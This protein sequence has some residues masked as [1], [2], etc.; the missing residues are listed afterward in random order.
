MYLKKQ[1]Q[2]IYIYIN[3]GDTRSTISSKICVWCYYVLFY[4]CVETNFVDFEELSSLGD[5][6]T[7]VSSPNITLCAPANNVAMLV[8]S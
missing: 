3:K 4:I 2:K 5:G 7:L 8:K 1:K 6:L